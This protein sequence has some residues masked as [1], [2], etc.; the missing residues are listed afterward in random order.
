[1]GHVDDKGFVV[2]LLHYL[3]VRHFKVALINRNVFA[4]IY[5]GIRSVSGALHYIVRL[6]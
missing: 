3:P 2:H 1:M 6:H 4:E 5:L